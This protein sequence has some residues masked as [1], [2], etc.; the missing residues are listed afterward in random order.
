M[1]ARHAILFEPV[2]KDLPRIDHFIAS[3]LRSV[4]LSQSHTRFAATSRHKSCRSEAVPPLRSSCGQLQM[5]GLNFCIWLRVDGTT[6][7]A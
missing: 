1:D 7:K 3:R 4:L 6:A 5:L 2:L